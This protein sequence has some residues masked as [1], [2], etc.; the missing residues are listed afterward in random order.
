MEGSLFVAAPMIKRDNDTCAAHNSN[1][2]C[3]IRRKFL[4][5]HLQQ[6]QR[7]ASAGCDRRGRAME[8]EKSHWHWEQ[9]TKYAVEG[10]KTTLLLNGAAA[11]ALMTFATAN[12]FSFLLCRFFR[13]LVALRSPRSLFSRHTRLNWNRGTPI[14]TPPI[15]PNIKKNGGKG[16]S[17]TEW[18][19]RRCW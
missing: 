10:I 16:S 15:T 17:G 14:A 12:E 1:K 13:S 2:N 3:A 7:E 5:I 18:H 4:Q 6:G 9:G 19:L 8:N 11:I